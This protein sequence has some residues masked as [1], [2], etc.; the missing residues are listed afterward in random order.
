[1]NTLKQYEKLKEMVQDRKEPFDDFINML[2]FETSWL[3]SPASTRFHLSEEGGL[4]K[5]S[6]GVTEN[7]LK[8]RHEF[9]PAISEE[10]C[11]IVGLFHDIGKVALDDEIL[12]NSDRFCEEEF[13]RMKMH[14]V[15]GGQAL[16]EAANEAGEESFLSVGRDVA[17]H[18]HE[19]WN[20]AGYPF[21]AEG[22]EIPLAARI[23][24]IADVY[25]AIT[26]ER[27]YKP[28]Y[29]HEETVAIIVENK[30]K[31]FDPNLVDVFLEVEEEFKAI[32]QTLSKEDQPMP[33]FSAVS[34]RKIDGERKS[35]GNK[36]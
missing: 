1:M 34:A 8:F 17:Y 12:F 27:R 30:G 20:G 32:R 25:D 36:P 29:S 9:A 13:E 22:E 18:H 31:Q 5:H 26:T 3:T 21:G 33:N 15:Y 14:T 16:E 4:L 2:E 6:V 23:V 10:S 19:H 35:A 24:A 7:L 28:A 11:L